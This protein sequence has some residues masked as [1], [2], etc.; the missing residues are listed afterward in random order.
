MRIAILIVLFLVSLYS[1]QSTGST[2]GKTDVVPTDVSN[3]TIRIENEELEYEII[4]IEPGFQSWLVTQRPMS[5][6]TE[7]TLEIRNRFYV[8]EWNIRVMNP[9]RYNPDLY[10]FAIE[11][12]PQIHYGLEV[13][14]LLYMYFEFFQKK[15]NQR[16]R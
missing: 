3:D 16:L 8:T 7:Q 9:M 15:Y 2:S 5:Y 14:Y 11:Y 6:F 4:I 13:N 1:C 10:A 12:D